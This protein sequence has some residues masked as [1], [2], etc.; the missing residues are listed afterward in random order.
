MKRA[1][2]LALSIIAGSCLLFAACVSTL[3]KIIERNPTGGVISY[4]QPSWINGNADESTL[5]KQFHDAASELCGS[6]PWIVTKEVIPMPE[7]SSAVRNAA[8]GDA[9]GALFSGGNNYQRDRANRDAVLN[10]KAEVEY[11]S[12]FQTGNQAH[13]KC[14]GPKK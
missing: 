10:Q 7:V 5:R 13:V 3:V 6:G 8:S 14:E 1:S 11:G 9:K 2:S 4:T 12:P